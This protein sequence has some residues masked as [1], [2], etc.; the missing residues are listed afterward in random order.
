MIKRVKMANGVSLHNKLKISQSNVENSLHQ[1]GYIS[2]F[3]VW[4]QHKFRGKKPTR[5]SLHVPFFKQNVLGD[6]K[7]M[8][9]NIV[10][11][12]D[13]CAKEKTWNKF[14]EWNFNEIY[15]SVFT[16]S[17]ELKTFDSLKKNRKSRLENVFG[18]KDKNSEKNCIAT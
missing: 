6:E 7:W 1:V 8:L 18:E 13:I 3:D 16:K 17:C 11:R 2:R 4:L 12:K 5:L 9:Y 14:C 15:I 10:K